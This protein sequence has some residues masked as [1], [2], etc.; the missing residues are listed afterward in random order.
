MIGCRIFALQVFQ[1]G[2]QYLLIKAPPAS[3]K[4]RALMFIAFDKLH[5]QGIR[6]AIIAV[7][8]QTIGARFNVEP[9]S[10]SGFWADWAV[11]P[12]WNLCNAPGTDGGDQFCEV[13]S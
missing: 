9:L 7:P 8:E 11:L 4:T 6:Q 12:T 3:G 5:N 13:F 1:Q 2:E 10:Q